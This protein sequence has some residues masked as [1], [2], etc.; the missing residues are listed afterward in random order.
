[1]MHNVAAHNVSIQNVK[2]SKCERH[3]TCSITKRAASQS[4]KCTL[5]NRYKTFC[6]GIRFVT[7]YVMSRLH[8]ENFMFWNS[9]VVCTYVL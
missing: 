7:L 5:R 6:N 8:F 4:I 3:I 1:M 9:Y 2:V